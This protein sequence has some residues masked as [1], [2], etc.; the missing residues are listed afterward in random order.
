MVYGISG[1]PHEFASNECVMCHT[2]VKNDPMSIRS[3][4]TYSCSNCHNKLE[5]IQSHPTDLYPTLPI[6]KDMPLMAGKMTCLTCHYAHP[7]KK[8]HFMKKHYFLRRAAR[9][10]LFCNICHDLSEKGHVISEKLHGGS[11]KVTD[12]SVRLDKISLE[13]IEC[14][15]TYINEPIDIGAGRWDHTGDKLSHP[16]GVSYRKVSMKKINDYKNP[17]LLSDGIRLFGGKIGCGTCHN[18]YSKIPN[19]LVMDNFGS[20]LCLECHLK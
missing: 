1:K 10:P 12:T 3:A 13:C 19:M 15:D 5:D 11:L 20:R 14:H 4:V 7:K 8:Q 17:T 9:G 6:P 16:V 18:I 2:N